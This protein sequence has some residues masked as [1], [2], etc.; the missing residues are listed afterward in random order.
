MI[1]T[2][3]VSG[4]LEAISQVEKV[5]VEAGLSPGAAE[6]K[7]RLFVEA[8]KAI[9]LDGPAM[10]FYVPGRVEV[11]GKHTDYAGGESLVAPIERGFCLVSVAR[12]DHRVILTRVETG[13]TIGFE[14]SAD[15][16]PVRGHWANYP[17]TVIRRV[18]R[19]F[20][21]QLLGVEIAFGS[22]LPSAAGMSSSSAFLVAI[23]LAL[24]SRNRL[25]VT[26]EWQSNIASVE[27]LASYLS[28]VENGQS[29][30]NL[31]GDRGVG[32][33]G[34]SEDHV[35]ILLG[36]PKHLIRYLYVPVQFIEAIPLPPGYVF[37]FGASGVVAEKTGAALE[38]YNAASNLARRLVSLWQQATGR[39]EP[40]LGAIV[41][42]GTQAVENLR[43]VIGEQV[44]DSQEQACLR[45]RLEH[46]LLEN[47]EVLPRAAAALR[48]GDLQGFGRLVDRSQWGAEHL[49]RNQVPETVFLA[50][51][52][53]ELGAAAASAFGAGFGGAVWALVAAEKAEYFLEQW[54][55]AY[56]SAFPERLS[57]A[58]FLLSG[59]GPPAFALTPS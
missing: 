14:I 27:D 13:E 38:K 7:S 8:R 45:R 55:E 49:L 34:G 25:D 28:T 30:R 31:A 23:F 1:P 2:F 17:M 22:D 42:L 36:R 33:L 16:Q 35:A 44:T 18:A 56:R 15:L 5:L 46:F 58:E 3:Q 19:N 20:P 4:N 26:P 10:G 9:P 29:F 59:A 6:G 51:S 39:E 53:R 21:R 37:A 41:R 50:R 54:K 52:A 40:T 32:T 43:K 47:E 11:L 57:A 12:E 48:S 24:A